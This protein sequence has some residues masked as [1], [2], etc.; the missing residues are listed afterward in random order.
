ME[1]GP[2]RSSVL[3]LHS[4]QVCVFIAA[5]ETRR[6]Q[7]VNL[8]RPAPFTFRDEA[9]PKRCTPLRPLHRSRIFLFPASRP[10]CPGGPVQEPGR[11]ASEDRKA[12]HN[13]RVWC[14]LLGALAASPWKRPEDTHLHG[15]AKCESAPPFSQS[16]CHRVL[17]CEDQYLPLPLPALQRC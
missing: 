6:R 17:E 4:E 5:L 7:A 10:H 9:V 15:T 13:V 11:R 8:Y 3:E 16:A 12:L 2:V 14:I 1:A